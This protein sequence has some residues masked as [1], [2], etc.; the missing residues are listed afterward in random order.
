MRRELA[1]VASAG[2]LTTDHVR[3][4][5]V[6]CSV[7][8]RTFWRWLAR[9]RSPYPLR[10]RAR[11]RFDEDLRDRVHHLAGNA[12]AVHRELLAAHQVGGPAPPSL[13]SVQRAVHLDTTI[14][15]E[16]PRKRRPPPLSRTKVRWRCTSST[17]REPPSPESPKSSASTAG[18]SPTTATSHDRPTIAEDFR[19]SISEGHTLE[20]ATSLSAD[21]TDHRPCEPMSKVHR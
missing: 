3:R 1:R 17:S 2:E 10:E 6:E 9:S 18:R 4:L 5:A 15:P 16:R 11:F 8:E 20:S 13:K 19:P 21:I 14:R 7:S 12:S